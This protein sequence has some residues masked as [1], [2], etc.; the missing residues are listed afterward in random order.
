MTQAFPDLEHAAVHTG[1]MRQ[2]WHMQ[3]FPWWLEGRT[4]FTGMLEARAPWIT[5][6]EPF[7]N[8]TCPLAQAG[9]CGRRW[10]AAPVHSSPFPDSE[11]AEAGVQ[12]ELCPTM[13]EKSS[14]WETSMAAVLTITSQFLPVEHI[15]LR[16]SPCLLKSFEFKKPIYTARLFTPPVNVCH[17]YEGCITQLLMQFHFNSHS[18]GK[19]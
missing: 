15:S 5:F 18:S 4:L 7:F 9:L 12:A 8:G 2:Q 14:L 10:R 6:E 3:R 16:P 17:V 1:G 13:S 11:E 19:Q